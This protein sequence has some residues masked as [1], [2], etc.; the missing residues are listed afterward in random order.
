MTIIGAL[1]KSTVDSVIFF[2]QLEPNELK[3]EGLIAEII[4]NSRF[5]DEI[6]YDNIYA[7]AIES[8]DEMENDRHIAGL[9]FK[10]ENGY[11]T[12]IVQDV[13]DSSYNDLGLYLN[14]LVF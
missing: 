2:C 10:V 11:K 6:G 4:S 14:E 7:V 9:I 8:N 1:C 13:A 5:K 12:I 3:E